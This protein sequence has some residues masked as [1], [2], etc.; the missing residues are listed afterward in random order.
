MFR[1][2]LAATVLAAGCGWFDE[3]A[4]VDEL[5]YGPPRPDFG[6]R[7]PADQGVPDAGAGA[8]AG[9]G[10]TCGDECDFC[11]C[12]DDCPEDWIRDR[13][14]DCACQYVDP[15]CAGPDGG[16][17]PDSGAESDASARRPDGGGRPTGE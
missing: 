8:D 7:Y 4:A 5:D 16:L 12:R 3:E 1:G 14:C 17:P 11:W 15:I 10:C 9:T 6:L 13:D 2:W